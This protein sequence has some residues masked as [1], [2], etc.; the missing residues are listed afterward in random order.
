VVAH[1]FH[2]TASVPSL[3]RLNADGTI[4]SSYITPFGWPSRIK[5][6]VLQPDNKAVV[7]TWDGTAPVRLNTDGSIDA[8]FRPNF[9]GKISSMAVQDDG[10]LLVAGS[11]LPDSNYDM[12]DLVARLNADGTPD[13]A[14]KPPAGG[15]RSTAYGLLI[16]PDKKILVSG[17]FAGG[18]DPEHRIYRLNEDGKLDTS[19]VSERV[20]GW[21]ALASDGKIVVGVDASNYAERKGFVVRLTS[22]GAYDPTFQQV[23]LLNMIVRC[24][25]TQPDGKVL[26]GGVF[27]TRAGG[28]AI[29]LRLNNDGSS[30]S[31]FRVSLGPL[32]P[33]GRELSSI[34]FSNGKAIIAGSF[35]AVGDIA[36]W[37]V[38]RIFLN[39]PPPT[40]GVSLTGENVQISWPTNEAGFMLEYTTQLNPG[41]WQPGTGVPSI[42]SGRFIIATPASEY[43]KFFRLK[44]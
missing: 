2:G 43:G 16:Q 19:F 44:R 33:N 40:L 18:Y 7:S 25:A 20:Q 23:P 26:V 14:F 31:T 1:A 42:S 38:A 5:L 11:T 36:R 9:A 37:Y 34:A 22:N 13:T 3:E 12:Y 32:S 6:L 24:V 8:T 39:D 15:R 10:K 27:I 21:S 29:L 41:N 35:T 17:S 4:D 28:G 30:D